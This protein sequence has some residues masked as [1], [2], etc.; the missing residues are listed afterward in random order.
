MP[1]RHSSQLAKRSRRIF[2]MRDDFP[3][4][5][6][7]WLFRPNDVQNLDYHPLADIQGFTSSHGPL[8]HQRTDRS[9]LLMVVAIG[10]TT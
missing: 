1:C 4:Q 9:F 10:G 6:R 7:C 8:V 5:G 2:S 3:F